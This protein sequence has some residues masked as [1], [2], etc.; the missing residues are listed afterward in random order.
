MFERHSKEQR[1]TNKPCFDDDRLYVTFHTFLAA[2]RVALG[3]LH[4]NSL[5]QLFKS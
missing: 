4:G 2:S 3:V 1:A 5:T